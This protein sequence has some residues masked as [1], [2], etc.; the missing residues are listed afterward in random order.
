[1]PCI[2]TRRSRELATNQ[3]FVFASRRSVRGALDGPAE[4]AAHVHRRCDDADRGR[5]A[6]RA[7]CHASRRV[8]AASS[9][10]IKPLYLRRDE[11]F[12]E[13]S[14]GRLKPQHTYIADAMTQTE[15]GTLVARDAVHL[16]A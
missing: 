8:G 16:D 7:R 2:S 3:A 9:P 5:H 15:V 14:M 4:A 6:R 10:P 11:A 12:A 1:M 13:L